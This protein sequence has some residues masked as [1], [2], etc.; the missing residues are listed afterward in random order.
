MGSGA[1]NNSG[2]V[3]ASEA[4]TIQYGRP[5]NWDALID[6]H[7]PT[8]DRAHTCVAISTRIKR[9]AAEVQGLCQKKGI[10]NIRSDASFD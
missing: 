1:A 4:L 3:S 6:E 7:V 10:T 2:F 8:H 5:R 9:L